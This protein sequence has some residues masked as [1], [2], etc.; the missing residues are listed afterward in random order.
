MAA[1][2]QGAAPITDSTFVDI[3][4]VDP[5]ILI[6]VRYAGPNNFTH[7]PLY[8]PGMPAMV[9]FSVARRLAFAQDY[10]KAHGYGETKP[11]CRESTEECWSKNRRVEFV[12]LKRS[13]EGEK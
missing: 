7:R 4:R 2:G 1:F 11:V 12:I 8:P 10:L 5:T 3:K 6:D 13:D 9:R